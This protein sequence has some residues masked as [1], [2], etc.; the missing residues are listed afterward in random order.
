MAHFAE[1]NENGT[2]LRVIVVHNNEL[3]DE[4]GNESEEK[5]IKFCK[6]HYGQETNWIQT[7]Y[8][9]TFRKN[10]AGPGYVYDNTDDA[11]IPPKPFITWIFN[12]QNY[13]WEPPIPRPDDPDN[14]YI[15]D[16]DKEDWKIIP[17]PVNINTDNG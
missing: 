10:F 6:D 3:L 4:N 1:L 14:L 16:F 9:S 13:K 17:D 5:G 11:F 12:K 7:S 2:V 8:N 15:W